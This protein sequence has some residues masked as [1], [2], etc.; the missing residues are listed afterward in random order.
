MDKQIEE[1]CPELNCKK[2]CKYYGKSNCYRCNH[3]DI[4]Q[5]RTFSYCEE[6]AKEHGCEYYQQEIPEDAIVLTR[7]EYEE[8]KQAKTLLEFREETIKLLEDANIRYAE[9]LE[10]KVNI[11]ERKETAKEIER[12]L[13]DKGYFE[14]GQFTISEN[15][16]IEIFKKRGVEVE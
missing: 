1:I 12:D 11:K 5:L 14:Y 6:K 16:F 13:E 3:K 2:D 9:T 8:L 7:E 15:D 10:L 4:C